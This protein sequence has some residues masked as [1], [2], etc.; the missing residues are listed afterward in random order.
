MKYT[1]KDFAT[2]IS[3]VTKHD[4][5]LQTLLKAF[6]KHACI[7]AK[8]VKKCDHCENKFA[9]VHKSMIDSDEILCDHCAAKFSFVEKQDLKTLLDIEDAASI[10]WLQTYVDEIRTLD[11]YSTLNS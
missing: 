1:E 4:Q 6:A 5:Q 11:E 8:H 10:R 3:I 2:L 7:L 9:T